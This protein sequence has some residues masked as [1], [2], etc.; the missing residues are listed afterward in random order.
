MRRLVVWLDIQVGH[1]LVEEYGPDW[2]AEWWHRVVCCWLE[3]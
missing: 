2:M 3:S 1:A